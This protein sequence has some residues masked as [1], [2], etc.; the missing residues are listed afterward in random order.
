MNELPPLLAY[1]VSESLILDLY[2][3]LI[4]DECV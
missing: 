2:R 1:S 3:N 4:D